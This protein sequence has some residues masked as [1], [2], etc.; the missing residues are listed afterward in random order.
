[1]DTKN[2]SVEEVMEIT[3]KGREFI[4]N[5]IANGT[6]PGSIVTSSGGRRNAHIPRR[7]FE[8][9]MDH[10]YRAPAD[11]LIGALIEVLTKQKNS[12]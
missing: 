8:E 9:Y 12:K 5:A 7:A 6:F 4:L 1:M 3:H 11:E 2:I 10:F